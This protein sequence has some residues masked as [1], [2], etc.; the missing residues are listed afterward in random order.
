MKRLEEL[1]LVMRAHLQV[2]GVLPWEGVG[3]PLCGPKAMMQDEPRAGCLRKMKVTP[4]RPECVKEGMSLLLRSPAC[5][6]WS[7]WTSSQEMWAFS[8]ADGYPG[9]Y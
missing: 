5:Q 6:L 7:C 9:C 1:T 2:Q 8:V 4:S 3:P